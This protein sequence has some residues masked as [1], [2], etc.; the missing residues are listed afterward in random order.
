MRTTARKQAIR[1]AFFRLGLH[2]TPKAILRALAQQDL[3][4]DEQL[5]HQVRIELV[6]E[7]TATSAVNVFSPVS[8]RA[9]RRRPQGFPSRRRSR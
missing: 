5:V 8:F 2:T 6:R 1:A 7:M 9:V 3:Q 4:V